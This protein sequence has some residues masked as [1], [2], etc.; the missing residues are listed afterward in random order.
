MAQAVLV[1]PY[2]EDTQKL[3]HT[4]DAAGRPV[5]VAAWCH[6]EET[7]KWQLWLAGKSFD[8]DSMRN[9]SIRPNLLYLIDAIA[10]AKAQELDLSDTHLVMTHH[11]VLQQMVERY[12][13]ITE[14]EPLKIRGGARL[15]DKDFD[16]MIIF[17]LILDHTYHG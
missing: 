3:L 5:A 7:E 11:P 6:D 4:L 15:A 10:T 17:R 2:P 16:S 8:E 12:G 13:H 9:Q 1:D 14:A